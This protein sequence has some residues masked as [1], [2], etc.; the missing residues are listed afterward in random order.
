[1][2]PKQLAPTAFARALGAYGLERVSRSGEILWVG[3][4]PHP[5]YRRE[6]VAAV[7]PTRGIRFVEAPAQAALVAALAASPE[8]ETVESLSI[9]TSHDYARKE[10][11]GYDHSAAIA[12][13][14]GGRWPRLTELSLGDMER[15]FNGHCYYGRV[16]N[17]TP[18]F[19]AMPRLEVLRLYGWFALERPVR[20]G[21]LKSLSVMLDDIGVSGGPLS[22]ETLDHLLSFRLPR[23]EG[24]D[25]SL[26]E[27]DVEDEYTIPEA[28]YAGD[29][30][31]ALRQM[32]VD[33]ISEETA[34][35]LIAWKAGRGIR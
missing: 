35:R 30:F 26:D 32:Q 7:P 33:R 6:A 13:L 29:G 20:H 16:G 27:A 21:R 19:E 23:L 11:A 8:A 28:F 24:L 9:G 31:P 12:A 1:M 10:G 17:I 3:L 22:Q 34:E 15:L 14:A 5:D 4:G 25:L 18:V 2:D